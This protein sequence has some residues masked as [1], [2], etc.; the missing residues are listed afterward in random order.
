MSQ[1]LKI[2]AFAFAVLAA[3]C[4][5][6]S[7]AGYYKWGDA[8]VRELSDIYAGDFDQLITSVTI[9][10]DFNYRDYNLTYDASGGTEVNL[11]AADRAFLRNAGI[12][13]A[14]ADACGL[15]WDQDNFLPMMTW[16]RG[17]L[18]E[19]KRQG[20][21]IAATGFIHGLAQGRTEQW[22]AE[23]D[24]QC[25]QVRPILQGNLFADQG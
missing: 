24:R 2:C 13:S 3:G 22:L 21:Q 25:E 10:E 1:M 20:Y 8:V 4:S 23:N 5:P 14:A 7:K 19:A 15:A 11:S 18:P 17:R 16:Q 6:T 9:P 12:I